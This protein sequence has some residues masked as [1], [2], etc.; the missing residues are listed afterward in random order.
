MPGNI[1]TVKSTKRPFSDC[2][3][4]KSLSDCIKSRDT[5]TRKKGQGNVTPGKVLKCLR[6]DL[7]AL[8]KF[9]RKEIEELLTIF[10]E[11]NENAEN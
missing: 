11:E 5:T 7:R 2:Y 9:K 3:R 10:D 4:K 1:R 6:I 8:K